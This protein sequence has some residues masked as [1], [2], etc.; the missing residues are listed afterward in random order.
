MTITLLAMIYESNLFFSPGWQ[1]FKIFNKPYLVKH[2]ED[3]TH[4]DGYVVVEYFAYHC[5]TA[6]AISTYFN[7][8]WYHISMF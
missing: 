4:Y 3:R 1:M 6:G 8:E 5:T 7:L 2:S